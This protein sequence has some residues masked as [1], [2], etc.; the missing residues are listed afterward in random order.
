MRRIIARSTAVLLLAACGGGDRTA[1]D[2]AAT[3]SAGTVGAPTTGTTGT[4]TGAAGMPAT[5]ASM[6]R[7]DTTARPDTGL[8]Q[9]TASDTLR[10][11]G[12]RRPG[13]GRP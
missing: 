3:D 12:S 2:T 4:D 9:D 13:S 7:P 5:D 1:A 11:P 8:T 10:P 6:P